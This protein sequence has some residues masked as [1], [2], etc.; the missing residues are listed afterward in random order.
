MRKLSLTGIMFLVSLSLMAQRTL[1]AEALKA[2]P[3]KYKIVN[4]V[5]MKQ[6][7]MARAEVNLTIPAKNNCNDGNI[8]ECNI[9]VVIMQYD[10]AQKE[11]LAMVE[12]R[13][14]FQSRL[15]NASNYK[16]SVDPNNT[17]V[18]YS[19]SK[20]V[21]LDG[22]RAAYYIQKNSCIM[23]QHSS[24]ESV[25]LKSL[26]GSTAK[27]VEIEING[28]V[29]SDEAISIVKELYAGLGRTNYLN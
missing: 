13:L 21:K 24:Y 22:G 28:G 6:G 8:G 9:K 26:Q 18:S 20:E 16:P 25:S 15:P 12:K 2:I 10:E 23:D 7:V 17:L 29:S 1:P 11:Y 19:P 4:Q 27:A 5:F 3:A 14:P